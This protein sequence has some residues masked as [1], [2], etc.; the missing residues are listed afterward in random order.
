MSDEILID[1][2]QVMAHV[3]VPAEERKNAQL[4]EISL[5]LFLDLS[6]A[7]HADRLSLSLDYAQ[8]H[9]KTIEIVQQ[10]PRELIETVAEDVAQ[11]L[12]RV[13]RVSRIEV[14]VRKFILPNTR[15]VAIRITRGA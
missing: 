2:I 6:P 4:L 11:G 9:Q 3:G 12:M 1:G 14:E 13:F 7:A 5:G 10:R 15:F 8:V